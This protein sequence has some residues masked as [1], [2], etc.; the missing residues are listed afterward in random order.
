M[1]TSDQAC[2]L[3]K[4]IKTGWLNG[5]MVDKYYISSVLTGGHQLTLQVVL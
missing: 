2:A 4:Y 1:A 5:Y 3:C